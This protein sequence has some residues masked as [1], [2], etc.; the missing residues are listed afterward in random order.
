MSGLRSDYCS[1]KDPLN[2]IIIIYAVIDIVSIVNALV[3]RNILILSIDPNQALYC[4][5]R[6]F[7]AYG[8]FLYSTGDTKR[9]MKL[10]AYNSK[11]RTSR[12]MQ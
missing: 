11:C 2:A 5:H 9:G 1:I 8:G 12:K 6:A 7:E 10:N 3:L 4:D